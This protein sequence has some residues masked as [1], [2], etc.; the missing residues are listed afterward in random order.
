MN[1]NFSE[2]DIVMREPREFLPFEQGEGLLQR[3]IARY[4][5]LIIEGHQNDNNN[6]K[7]FC[8]LIKP[9]EEKLFNEKLFK[10]FIDSEY[11]GEGQLFEDLGKLSKSIN[12][13]N[14]YVNDILH[15]LTMIT[16]KVASAEEEFPRSSS[17]I[18][19]NLGVDYPFD[20]ETGKNNENLYFHLRMDQ[21]FYM[22]CIDV[23][24]E[25]CME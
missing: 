23:Y 21:E 24:E 18:F 3:C 16:I 20:I 6:M 5:Q 1:D 9:E 19:T 11:D 10:M 17:S 13:P 7:A 15:A 25:L 8:S 12:K 2:Y 4:I 14:S 22:V